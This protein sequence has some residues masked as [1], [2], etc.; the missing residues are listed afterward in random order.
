MACRWRR[1][2][3]VARR[4]WLDHFAFFTASDCTASAAG[5]DLNYGFS[6]AEADHIK[7]T[8]IDANPLLAQNKS[9]VWW[10]SAA[11]NGAHGAVWAINSG[12]N[13]L[14]QADLNGD[15]TVDFSPTVIGV[16]DMIANDFL[17]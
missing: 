16:N 13:T 12:A 10:R 14:V 6:R 2:G 8:A 15:K 1:L 4:V 7:L 3:S 5:R 11:F 17:R 9:F